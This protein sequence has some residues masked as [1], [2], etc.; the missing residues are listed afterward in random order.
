MRDKSP[1]PPSE[2]LGLAADGRTLL[3]PFPNQSLCV[4]L[5]PV[6]PLVTAK[7][8]TASRRRRLPSGPVNERPLGSLPRPP[9]VDQSSAG[10]KRGATSLPPPPARAPLPAC[11]PP[12]AARGSAPPSPLPPA[13]RTP[14]Y[15][16]GGG[17]GRLPPPALLPAAGALDRRS[18]RKRKM[19]SG[20]N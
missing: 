14:V 12:S 13:A 19:T 2:G 16:E 4:S 20:C 7:A 1:A 18:R 5:R 15:S 3:L 10:P 17:S 8:R 9:S 11:L 6:S